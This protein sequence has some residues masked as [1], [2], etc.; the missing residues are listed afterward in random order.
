MNCSFR[1]ALS[2]LRD[3]TGVVI[4]VYLPEKVDSALA[5]RL[6]LDTVH[7]C[8]R[9]V[10][11]PEAICLSA[12]GEGPSVAAADAV[13]R[14]C[15]VQYVAARRNRGKLSALRL[16]MKRLMENG[17]FKYLATV[18]QDG[19]HFPNELVNLVRAAR[20]IEKS[21]AANR[22]MVLGRR[23]SRHRPMGFLRGELEEFADRML[24][25]ALQYNAAATGKPLQLQFTTALDEFPDFHSDFKLFS[26]A[27][28]EAVFLSKPK[29]AGASEDAYYRHAVEAVLT[30]ESVLAG[31]FLVSVNRSTLDEQPVTTFGLLN[32]QRMVA[33][34]IIWPCKRLKIPARFVAQWMSNHLPRLLLGSYLPDGR[35]ELLGIRCLVLSAFG[36]KCL[37]AD[38]CI[39]RPEFV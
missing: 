13:A 38:S 14:E 27:A 16:G 7:G 36:L 18:D 20:H 9:E 25:D 8:V 22:V 29:L 17:R 39:A 31:A 21:V 1:Q 26:R 3:A 37:P 15:G 24:L 19:D 12:D 5:T 10:E 32:R 34:K 6:L 4:P 23:I 11:R 35:E 28:A 30:V 33:D 2:A